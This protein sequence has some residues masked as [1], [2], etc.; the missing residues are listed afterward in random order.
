MLLF[1]GK[2]ASVFIAREKFM[3]KT[4]ITVLDNFHLLPWAW[5]FLWIQRTSDQSK[6]IAKLMNVG[7]K[8]HHFEDGKPQ[9]TSVF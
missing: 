9:P 4:K 7:Y 6:T 1:E 3:T 8:S 2:L 5:Q